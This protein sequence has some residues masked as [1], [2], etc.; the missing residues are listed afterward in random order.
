[1]D[2]RRQAMR[3]PFSPG[4]KGAGHDFRRTLDETEG[5]TS[6]PSLQFCDDIDL[7]RQFK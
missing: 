3:D 6:A 5:Q 1:M 2:Q 7:K 4:G